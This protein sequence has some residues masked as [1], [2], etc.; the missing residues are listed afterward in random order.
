MGP[1]TDF[2][3]RLFAGLLLMDRA[4]QPCFRTAQMGEQLRNRS[5]RN[6]CLTR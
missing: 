4:S 5:R 1:S 2:R 6:P 3:W